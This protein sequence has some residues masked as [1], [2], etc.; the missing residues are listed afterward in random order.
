[1]VKYAESMVKENRNEDRTPYSILFYNCGTFVRNVLT[2]GGAKVPRYKD[3]RPNYYIAYFWYT[4][5]DSQIN[6]KFH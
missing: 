1:M 2:A 4:Y 5:P 6:Y 3:P